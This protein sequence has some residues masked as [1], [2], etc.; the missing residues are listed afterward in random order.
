MRDAGKGSGCRC[1]TE[2]SKF[3][4]C[5]HRAIIEAGDISVIANSSAGDRSSTPCKKNPI[6]R[7][8]LC[9]AVGLSL[10]PNIRKFY[11]N[12][13]RWRVEEIENRLPVFAVPLPPVAEVAARI[14]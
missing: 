10:A 12:T 6:H 2:G 11:R 1:A 4:N 14:T 5:G 3:G 9:R 8:L 13:V 7:V